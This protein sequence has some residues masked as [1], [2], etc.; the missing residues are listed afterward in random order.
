[1]KDFGCM[2]DPGTS[3][4]TFIQCC[5]L[6]GS[7]PPQSSKHSR[8]ESCCQR[9]CSTTAP[10]D[11]ASAAAAAAEAIQDPSSTPRPT[12]PSLTGPDSNS[13]ALNSTTNSTDA[14]SFESLT[15]IVRRL[16]DMINGKVESELLLKIAQDF[17]KFRKK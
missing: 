5:P 6:C 15:L 10:G 2:C 8:P 11:A 3:K 9:E 16:S 14:L 4:S 17:P 7:Q 12:L 13:T 1:M